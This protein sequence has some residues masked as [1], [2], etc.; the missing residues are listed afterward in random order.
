MAIVN[1]DGFQEREM[2]GDTNGFSDVNDV[3]NGAVDLDLAV[4]S[5]RTASIPPGLIT[6]VLLILS[7]ILVSR[8]F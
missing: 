4:A 1:R 2:Y 7:V 3:G 6:I 8:L 5:S